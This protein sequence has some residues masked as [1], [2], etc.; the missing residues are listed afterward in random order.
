MCRALKSFKLY[1]T[2]SPFSMPTAIIC[3]CVIASIDEIADVSAIAD[4]SNFIPKLIRLELHSSTRSAICWVSS[5]AGTMRHDDSSADG[6]YGRK[7][8]KS[9]VI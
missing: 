6:L 9:D 7:F 4:T 1:N 2:S 3:I 8:D 5:G